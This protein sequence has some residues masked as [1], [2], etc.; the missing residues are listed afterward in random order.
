MDVQCARHSV[1]SARS[2][3]SKICAARK[4]RPFRRRTRDGN[5]GRPA[6]HQHHSMDDRDCRSPR[7]SRT[8][9]LDRD[10]VLQERSAMTPLEI[11]RSEAAK[12][13]HPFFAFS[14]GENANGVELVIASKVADVISPEYRFTFAE[15]DIA[16]SQF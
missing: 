14:V 2:V 13:E 5:L 8:V 6:D 10:P 1:R 3:P 12:Y 9:Y 15:R 16:S 11:V 7:N 4:I